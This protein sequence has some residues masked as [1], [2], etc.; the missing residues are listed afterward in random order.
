M[1]VS[2]SQS[3]KLGRK[4]RVEVPANDIAV[5]EDKRLKK[6]SKKIKMDGFRKGK[7]PMQIIKERYG[8]QV[9]QEVLSD[10]IQSSLIDALAQEKLN[11]AGMPTIEDTQF[12]QGKPLTYTAVFEVYPEVEL[13][14]F[15]KIKVEK[16]VA[17]VTDADVEKT[18]QVIREQYK[19]WMPVERAAKEGDQVDI[20]FVGTID[21][22]EFS[23]GKAEN[24]KL[25]IGAGNMIP[26]FAEGIIGLK[27]NE[28]KTI[29]L[30]F[31][32][33]Y[34]EKTL[35]GK[36]AQFAIKLNS[37]AEASLPEIN[38]AFAKQLNIKEGTIDALKIEV[39]KNMQ[40]ELEQAIKT[41]TKKQVMDALFAANKIEL[42][43]AAVISEV[44][45]MQQQ[46]E[47]MYGAQAAADEIKAKNKEMFAKEA[48]RRVALGLIV[49]EIVKQ[50]QL[51]VD[52]ARVRKMIE[53][54][55]DAYEKPAEIISM[56]YN[57]K[58]RLAGVEAL[59]LEEQV[60][61]KVL[62]QAKVIE[63]PSAF[64]RLIKAEKR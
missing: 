7:V 64:D 19:N 18:L 35:A 9:R 55:A 61:D 48:E 21:G 46:A 16:L 11:P 25:E 14:A 40:R 15:N 58:S 20:N 39:R 29:A 57:D 54:M 17:E 10:V 45:R 26:G 43:Q 49:A 33:E 13:K 60:V 52:A 53:D 56:Y 44:D 22:T 37:V 6:L 8:P 5:S 62:E 36:E 41:K 51:K 24:F 23:G 3:G 31:P 4:M 1:Q 28:E 27:P 32:E 38:D 34:G 63:K 30:T 42:P 47:K 59:I 12:E 2:V 50:Q